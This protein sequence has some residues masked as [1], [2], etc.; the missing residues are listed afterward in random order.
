MNPAASSRSL[1]ACVHD[2]LQELV[3]G[4]LHPLVFSFAPGWQLIGVAGDHAF[5]GVDDGIPAPLADE[6]RDLFVGLGTEQDQD[7]PFVELGGGRP[8]H[9]RLIGGVE[10]F[11]VLLLDASDERERQQAQQQVGNEAVLAGL[12]QS[13]AIGQ[14]KEIRDT[15]ERQHASLAEADAFKGALIAT[16]SHEFR[17]PLTSIFGYLHLLERRH[18]GACGLGELKA[19]RRSASYLLALAENLL[20]Y[21]RGESGTMP[22]ASARI[23]LATL[24]EDLRAMFRPLAEDKGLV[25]DVELEQGS[26]SSAVLDGVRLRQ[27]A[28]NL[29]SNAVRYTTHGHIRA[30]F[31]CDG[32]RLRLCVEDTGIGI[33]EDFQARVFQ[34]FNRGAQ[35]GSK[36]AGLGLSIVRRLVAQMRGHL[37]LRS[38]V[39]EGSCFE[40]EL[41]VESMPA[42]PAAVAAQPGGEWHGSADV[43][44][45]DDDPDIAQ[46]LEALLA[47]LGCTVRIAYDGDAALAEVAR[48]PPDLLLID[49]QLPGLSGNAVVFQLRARGYR[50]RIVTLSA[51]GTGSARE[52]ALHAGADHYLTKPLDIDAFV[53][54]MRRVLGQ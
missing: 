16:L 12:A 3:V 5:H 10:V 24:V 31:H 36:G 13:R 1:P 34:P 41:P 54:E 18:A 8:L 27:I 51:S 28:I 42:D 19:I 23:T 33:S 9:V 53:D 14:L 21:A 7:F 45:V 26:E 50:G 35:A 52:A 46:L 17:T 44:V 43:L 4:R 38:R 20:E 6:L 2:Y 25:L 40:V 11:H 15:L 22:L 30:C 32:A 39:G 29:V 48:Q 49:V 47:D 37:R